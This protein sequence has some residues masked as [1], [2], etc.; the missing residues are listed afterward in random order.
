MLRAQAFLL[1]ALWHAN[2]FDKPGEQNRKRQLGAAGG[3]ARGP[4]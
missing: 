1:Y 3:L 4:R 2:T